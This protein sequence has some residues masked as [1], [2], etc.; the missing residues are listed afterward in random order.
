M[1]YCFGVIL[2]IA[3]ITEAGTITGPNRRIAGLDALRGVAILLVIAGHFLPTAFPHFSTQLVS[4]LGGAGVLLFFYLSG[5]LIFRNVQTQPPGIFLVRRFFKLFPAYWVNV[6]VIT[7]MAVVLHVGPAVDLKAVVA[8]LLMVQEFTD[9]PLSNPVYW[10]LQIEVK[11]YLLIVAYQWCFGA[12]WIYGLLVALLLVN[13]VLFPVLQ[14]GSTLVTYLIAFFPG[15]AA[16]RAGRSWLEPLIVTAVT[17]ANLYLFLPAGNCAMA[18]YA[19]LF[20]TMIVLVARGEFQSRNLLFF[21]KIS[22]SHYLYH[23]AI[24]FLLLD[25]LAPDGTTAMKIAAL[26]GTFILTTLIAVV[27]FYGIEKPAI[28]AGHRLEKPLSRVRILSIFTRN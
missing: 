4:T 5:F 25:W 1:L 21:G 17:A 20:G 7:F 23:S 2:R 14:R 19:M 11:F 24:G 9:S 8:N 12:R 27:S 22:Y 18:S 16:A 3:V 13:A 10:T 15:I 26:L 28:A 6:I